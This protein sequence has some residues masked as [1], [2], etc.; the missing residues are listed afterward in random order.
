MF[1]EDISAHFCLCI[2]Y[3]IKTPFYEHMSYAEGTNLVSADQAWLSLYL[4]APL[5]VCA[6]KDVGCSPAG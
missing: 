2:T 3:D 5:G 1:K 4:P 6:Q